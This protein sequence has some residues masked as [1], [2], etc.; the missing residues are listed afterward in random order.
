MGSF[1]TATDTGGVGE[2]GLIITFIFACFACLDTRFRF[3]RFPP[4]NRKGG[5]ERYDVFTLSLL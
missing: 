1:W 2:P 3:H 4:K 5:G